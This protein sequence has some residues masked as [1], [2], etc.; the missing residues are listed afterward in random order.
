MKNLLSLLLIGTAVAVNANTFYVD[1]LK[2][3]NSNPGTAQKP[4]AS[5]DKGIKALGM[6]DRLE[7]IANPGNPYTRPYYGPVGKEYAVGVGGTADK[8]LVIN[9]NGATI[10]GLA[11]IPVEKWTKVSEGIYQLPFW[12]MSNLYRN[13]KTQDY[14]NPKLKI[15][16]VNGEN[17][18]NALSR[19]EMETNPGSFWWSRAEKCVY[20]RLPEGKTLTELTIQLPANSGFYTHKDHTR[21]ENFTVIH[22]WN[23]GFDTA[24]FARNT[25]YRNCV[26]IDNCGQG[27]S[28][29]G[30]SSATYE[31]CLALRCGSAGFANIHKSQ[32]IYKRC[33]LMENVFEAGAFSAAEASST[34]YDCL[35]IDNVPAEQLW[36]HGSANLTLNNSV[37]KVGDDKQ[38]VAF[39]RNGKLTLNRCTVVG[40]RFFTALA[41]NSSGI[42]EIT[43]SLL[44]NFKDYV[45]AITS[46]RTI[47]KN[48]C[49]FNAPAIIFNGQN[50][51]MSDFSRYQSDSNGDLNSRFI[52]KLPLDHATGIPVSVDG[53][54]ATL[55]ES[56]WTQ[57]RRYRNAVT[58]VNGVNLNHCK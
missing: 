32:V 2:G 25:V 46:D 53:Q 37:V 31:D 27:F 55:P 56:V 19:Q 33:V 1:N 45:F 57:Y 54:G 48:N 41:K 49:Y 43:N 26:A 20:F 7:V 28:C 51:R 8:P 11:V 23:D 24:N 14:W 42:L 21:I 9:G 6:S 44:G 52:P 13:F 58:T 22:S 39:V 12:P 30:V 18:R 35:V 17:A 50:Y 5:L 4:F 34:L 47:L 10:S 36:A 16:F 29:H 15:W 3:S 38:S 40:G